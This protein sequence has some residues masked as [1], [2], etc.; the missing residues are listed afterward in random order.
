MF[1]GQRL[2]DCR[3]EIL[4]LE[5]VAHLKITIMLCIFVQKEIQREERDLCLMALLEARDAWWG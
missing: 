5:L 1:L 4:R 3:Y 2:V